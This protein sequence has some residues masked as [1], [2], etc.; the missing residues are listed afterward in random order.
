MKRCIDQGGEVPVQFITL[1]T[2]IYHW[3]DLATL[4]REYEARTTARGAAG[5]IPWSLARRR[6]TVISVGSSTT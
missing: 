2:A 5:A 6:C 3:D 1:T 4:L